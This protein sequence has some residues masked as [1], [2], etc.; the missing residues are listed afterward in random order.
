MKNVWNYGVGLGIF[1]SFFTATAQDSQLEPKQK[2]SGF[3]HPESVI[4]D[5]GRD[6]LYVSN[7]GEKEPQDGFISKITINGDILE[8]NW[9]TGLEDPK[10]L[11]LHND[12]LYVT[13]NTFLVIMDPEEGRIIEQVEVHDASFLNDITASKNGEIFISD[14]GKS[15]IYKRNRNGIIEEWLIT[16][17]LEFPNGLLAVEDDL[18]IAAWGGE[19][20]GNVLRL[21]IT[22]RHLELVSQRG[23]G[24]LDGIQ[25]EDETNFIISDWST[26]DIHRIDREG[27]REKM[28]T[29]GKSVGD[30]LYL[31]SLNRLFLPMN[32]QN[33]LWIYDLP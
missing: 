7:I 26:G 5:P 6:V 1:I 3:S 25:Q 15:S 12:T 22:N 8:L 29:S 20:P 33:E 31:K 19:E 18:Y 11:L 24:N 23:I 16:E 10:G 30:L 27:N 17:K 28:F 13:D 4:H 9:I 21:N 2:I 32:I 14:S